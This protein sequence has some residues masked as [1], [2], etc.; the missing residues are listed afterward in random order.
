MNSG[1]MAAIRPWKQPSARWQAVRRAF[2]EFLA[3]PSAVIAGFLLLAVAGYYLDRNSIEPLE[4]L[5][6]LLKQ[7]VFADAQATSS[8]LSSIASGLITVT[9]ITISLLLLSVAQSAASMTSEVVDQ[10]LRRRYNQIYF[11]FFI[12]LS[13]YALLTLATVNEPFN[14]VIGATLAFLLTVVALLLLL[15]LL[16]T[17]LNQMRSVEIVETLH[18]YLMQA[19]EREL[20]LV[21]RTKRNSDFQGAGAHII[22]ADRRGFVTTIDLDLLM[23]DDRVR[24][25]DC[26]VCLKVSTGSY[27]A[28]GDNIAIVNTRS[29]AAGHDLLELVRRAIHLERQ[30]DVATDPAHGIEQL[31]TI[32]WT[33][34]SSSKSNPAP[35]LLIIRTLRDVMARWSM[36]DDPPGSPPAAVVYTD[37]AFDQLLSTFESLGIVSTE[38][39]QH[40]NFTEVMH[41]FA[42]MLER[43]PAR[44]HPHAEDVILRLLSGMADHVLTTELDST[45]HELT[46]SLAAA[47]CAQT[48]EA[49]RAAHERMR[50]TIGKLNSRSTRSGS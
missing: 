48:A 36:E 19:R 1:E 8:L 23:Q 14:P 17:S 47:G 22:R 29:E 40:Q 5:R 10:F 34:I 42:V 45:L 24:S 4:P 41:T 32:A 18:D 30:R 44:Y 6:A 2:R 15:T 25:H 43:M 3:I 33:S 20:E 35:G 31:E 50:D 49:V 13:L 39:M 37:T 11:G 9:S 21:Q 38:S 27:V 26:E 12:G 7:H 28:F 16:Y 46:T